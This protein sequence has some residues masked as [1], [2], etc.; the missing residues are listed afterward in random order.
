MNRRKTL[1]TL[2]LISSH[3]LFPAILSNFVAGCKNAVETG[4]AVFEPA[5]FTREEMEAIIKTIDILLPATST[6]SAS[7]VGTH[8]FLDEVFA[9]CMTSEQQAMIREGLADLQTQLGES[10]DPMVLLS[11][12]DR[13]AYANEE[14]AA[15]FKVIKQYAMIGF[16]TSQEGITQAANYVKVP[17]DYKGEIPLTEGTLN[18]GMTN[19]RFYL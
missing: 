18:Y 15:Y 7:Q 17:G 11:E 8:R 1:Q 4:E 13:Q 2:G 16:F 14:T 3:A 19:L 10:D 6:P 9:K 5:F 12:L